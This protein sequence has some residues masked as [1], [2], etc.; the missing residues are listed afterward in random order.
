MYK[1]NIKLN[2]FIGE[3]AINLNVHLLTKLEMVHVFC[4]FLTTRE[5]K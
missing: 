5:H 3:N 4:V 1:M 2:T